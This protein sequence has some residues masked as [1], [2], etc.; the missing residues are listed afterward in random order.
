MRRLALFATVPMLIAPGAFGS[1]D[2][3]P[4]LTNPTPDGITI[5][6]ETIT[7]STTTVQVGDD[8]RPTTV[9]AEAGADDL[10]LDAR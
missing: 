2:I 10:E 1:R 5:V 7:P 4:W 9:I 6:W 3:G 8:E